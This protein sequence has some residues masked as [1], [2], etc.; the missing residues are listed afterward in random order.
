MP[1]ASGTTRVPR[2]RTFDLL[3]A[4]LAAQ[5]VGQAAEEDR[6]SSDVV[7]P[8]YAATG[9]DFW[10]GVDPAAADQLVQARLANLQTCRD[11]AGRSREREHLQVLLET[12]TIGASV[13]T[14]AATR[15]W[16]KSSRW[17]NRSRWSRMAIDDQ[18]TSG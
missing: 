17:S 9:D 12:T 13:R 7:R 10:N 16:S 5:I 6:S 11:E 18:Q 2:L 1:P 3:R 14:R 4:E 15:S 8:P